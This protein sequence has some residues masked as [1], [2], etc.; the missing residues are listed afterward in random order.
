[1]AANYLVHDLPIVLK[2][3]IDT[4]N[5]QNSKGKPPNSAKNGGDGKK[6][7]QG[8]QME[9]PRRRKLS[10]LGGTDQP[11]KAKKSTVPG[12]PPVPQVETQSH[13]SMLSWCVIRRAGMGLYML[14][15]CITSVLG[16]IDSPLF[17]VFSLLDFFRRRSGLLVLRAVILAGPNLLRS[18]VLGMIVI[19][20]FGFY[21]YAYFS[22]IVNYEQELCH[23]PFQCISKH[24]LDSLTGDLTTVLGDS[25]GQAYF[26]PLVLWVD[27]W[28]SWKSFVLFVSI[29]FWVLLLK[30]IIQGQIIDAFAEKRNNDNALREDLETKCFVSSIDR[31]VFNQYPGEWEK[32]RGGKYA[33]NYLLFF[34]YLAEKDAEEYNGLE[35]FVTEQKEKD[36]IDFLPIN[37]FIAQ[38]RSEV[39]RGWEDKSGETMLQSMRQQVDKVEGDVDEVKDLLNKIVSLLRWNRAVLRGGGGE[40]PQV[41]ASTPWTMVLQNATQRST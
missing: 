18:L 3:A 15:L 35:N 32:R 20:C 22:N 8:E 27:L 39:T 37:T 14:A 40:T 17:F 1:M 36:K 4:A 31:F 26:P 33:W 2:K 9:P 11:G 19:I 12:L 41:A 28:H 10:I 30:G 5:R 34:T 16:V 23:S 24:I 6:P 38:Q 29:V 25:L 21:S 13:Y 7:G